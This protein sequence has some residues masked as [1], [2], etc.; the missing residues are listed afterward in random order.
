M[1]VPDIV[2]VGILLSRLGQDL[3]PADPMLQWTEQA[4]L[5]LSAARAVAPK[6]HFR[7]L[8][9]QEWN[10]PMYLLFGAHLLLLDNARDEDLFSQLIQRLQS[11]LP[12]HPD[13]ELLALYGRK[14][15]PSPPPR[16]ELRWPPLLSPT[17]RLLQ[18]PF[19]RDRVI[20]PGHSIAARAGRSQWANSI[21]FLWSS[22][23]SR[24]RR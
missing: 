2:N 13:V 6:A 21:W 12:N 18:D 1:R 22:R 23:H 14:M 3:E 9:Q 16:I 17:W 19:M 10:E 24:S 20:I 4:R 8:L 7:R 5:A 11:L 15:D